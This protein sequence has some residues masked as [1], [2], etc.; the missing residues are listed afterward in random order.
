MKS[1]LHWLAALLFLAAPALRAQETEEPPGLKIRA[2]AFQTDRPLGEI[3]AHDPVAVAE[4]V[5]GVKVAVKKYLNHEVDIVP[6]KGSELVFTTR[7]DPASVRTSADV[8]AKVQLPA[9]LK[10]SILIF[11][12]GS[13]KAG[14][15]MCRVLVI[16]DQVRAFPRGSLKVLNLSPLPVRIQLEK[17]NFD[18]KSGETRLIEDPPVGANQTS[19]MV[20]FTHKGGEWQR[21]GAGVWPHPGDK[22]V[23]Q[24]LFENPRSKQI[25]MTGIRD[26]AVRDN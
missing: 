22:R 4:G 26:V 2:V 15:P 19:G 5:A 1:V 3:Y 11:L 14:E 18:F 8:V 12:P 13:G 24:I 7:P 21:I 20:A 10:S 23:L 9:N 16:D 6:V 25:E 17:K